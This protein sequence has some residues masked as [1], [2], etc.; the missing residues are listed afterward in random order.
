[1]LHV[2]KAGYTRATDTE[3]LHCVH[4]RQADLHLQVKDREPVL[5][6]ERRILC[7]KGPGN[8]CCK[9]SDVFYVDQIVQTG[10]IL[11]KTLILSHKPYSRALMIC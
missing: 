2:N 1:M 6:C 7:E 8:P 5:P 9:H 3:D 11:I 10:A 4:V